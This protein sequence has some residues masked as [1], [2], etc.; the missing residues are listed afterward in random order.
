MVGKL[1]PGFQDIP[2]EHTVGDLRCRRYSERVQRCSASSGIAL[3]RAA[4]S[5]EGR[6]NIRFGGAGF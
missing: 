2:R 6:P 3:V 5:G 4:K 1:T